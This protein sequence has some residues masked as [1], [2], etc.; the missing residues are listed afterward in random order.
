MKCFRFEIHILVL[1]LFWV[2]FW[3]MFFGFFFLG[4]GRGGGVAKS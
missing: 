3:L 2:F 1:I 4:R